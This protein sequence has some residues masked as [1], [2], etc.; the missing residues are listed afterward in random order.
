MFPGWR[1]VAAASP[2]FGNDRHHLGGYATGLALITNVLQRH[3]GVAAETAGAAPPDGAFGGL[4]GAML[5]SKAHSRLTTIFYFLFSHH[6]RL[7]P[8]LLPFFLRQFKRPHQR[9]LRPARR[10]RAL[11]RARPELGNHGGLTPA[12]LPRQLYFR[13]EVTDAL[14]SLIAHPFAVVTHISGQTG[15]AFVG[16]RR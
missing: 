10:I 7:N 11:H 14:L 12:M 9:H 4:A 13:V 3:G 8:M 6:N 15:G 5:R 1:E 16:S 2:A